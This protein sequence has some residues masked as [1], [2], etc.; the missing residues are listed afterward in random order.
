MNNSVQPPTYLKAGKISTDYMKDSL[1]DKDSV[2]NKGNKRVYKQGIY[3][4]LRTGNNI[5]NLYS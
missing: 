5:S 4:Y 3:Y 1:F 2:E